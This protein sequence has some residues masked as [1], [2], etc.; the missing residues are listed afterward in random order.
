MFPRY[1]F[2]ST[3]SAT[4]DAILN[5]LRHIL[6]YVY[7]R[8]QPVMVGHEEVSAIKDFLQEHNCSRIDKTI[9]S[10]GSHHRVSNEI[11]LIRKG[12]LVEANVGTVKLTLPSLG[13]VLVAEVRKDKVEEFTQVTD[14]LIGSISGS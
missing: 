1:V 14:S 10:P 12:S 5:Q 8:D 3:E 9:V 11:Q 6:S 13:H 7:W 2:V 4:P